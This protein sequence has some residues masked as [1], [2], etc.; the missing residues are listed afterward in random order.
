MKFSA[1]WLALA[2]LLVSGSALA[3]PTTDYG[4]APAPYPTLFADDGARHT[5]GTTDP[6]FRLGLLFD[7]E[8]DGAP[9]ATAQGDDL[10]DTDDEDGVSLISGPLDPGTTATFQVT[11][12]GQAGFMDAWCDFN[13]DGDWGDAGEQI[14]NS[15]AVAVGANNI[16]VSVPAST[17]PNDDIFCRFRLS[18]TGGLSPTGLNSVADAGGEVEDY[19][20][21]SVP[22]ELTNFNVE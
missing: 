19:V 20:F 7:C 5:S 4:D 3:C 2:V 12:A 1:R 17:S 18:S 16:N 15:T 8:A 11:V 9:N 14:M 22:V 10:T 6:A 13:A 21:A